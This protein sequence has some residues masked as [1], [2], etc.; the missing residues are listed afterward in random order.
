MALLCDGEP[1]KCYVPVLEKNRLDLNRWKLMRETPIQ[2]PERSC[3]QS[4]KV[5]RLDFC[6]IHCVPIKL[7]YAQNQVM[8]LLYK[9]AIQLIQFF[10]K[11]LHHLN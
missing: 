9:V 6:G 8:T 2:F 10:Q 1:H 3:D 11:D 7:C 4:L 5:V